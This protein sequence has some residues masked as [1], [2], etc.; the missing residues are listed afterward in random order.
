MTV[1]ETFCITVPHCIVDGDEFTLWTDVELA[2]R[3]VSIEV[4][5]KEAMLKDAAFFR[6][7]DMNLLPKDGDVTEEQLNAAREQYAL[8]TS[9]S[10]EA[11]LKNHALIEQ[12]QAEGSIEIQRPVYKLREA[13]EE[14]LAS[15]REEAT[16]PKGIDESRYYVALARRLFVSHD[17]KDIPAAG[18]FGALP[19]ALRLKLG[20]EA[21][22]RANLDETALA[23][24]LRSRMLLRKA[25]ASEPTS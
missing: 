8:M 21:D 12:A 14:D 3:R 15:A 16:S 24:V 2:R 1:A 6:Q 9:R 20:Q 17:R 22:R 25:E 23:F 18:G 11:D 19:L 7:W 10:F 5:R 4:L 13:T